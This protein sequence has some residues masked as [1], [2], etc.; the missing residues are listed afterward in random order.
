MRIIKDHNKLF[1]M[2]KE[3]DKAKLAS[4]LQEHLAYSI[5]RM[6]NHIEINYKDYFEDSL[7]A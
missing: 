4:S 7:E 3:K 2:I 5:T 1:E 6:K